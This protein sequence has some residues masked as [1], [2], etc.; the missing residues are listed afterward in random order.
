MSYEV[1]STFTRIVDGHANKVRDII[2]SFLLRGISVL[3][4]QQGEEWRLIWSAD[5]CDDDERPGAEDEDQGDFADGPDENPQWF[6]LPQA[7]PRQVLP[8]QTEFA[9]KQFWKD[10]IDDLFREKGG[11]GPGVTRPTCSAP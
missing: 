2:E 8:E 7:L 6:V 11:D 10:A 1:T 5:E 9:N 3:L 4:N